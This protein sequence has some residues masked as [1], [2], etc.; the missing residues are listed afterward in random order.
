MGMDAELL[1]IG[2][3]APLVRIALCYP[4][5]FYSD[6]PLGATII[7][8]VCV[9]VTTDGSEKLARALG[10]TSWQFEQ[11]CGLSGEGADLDLLEE[12]AEDGIDAVLRFLNLRAHGFKFYYL[13]NG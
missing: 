13:P 2:K 10:I 4:E 9:C 8:T 3:Y 12:S 11:H 7:T 5:D 6:T 1:A